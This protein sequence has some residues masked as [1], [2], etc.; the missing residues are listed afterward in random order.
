MI[1]SLSHLVRGAAVEAVL[2]GSE[3][4]TK[5]TLEAVGIDH[6]AEQP[7]RRPRGGTH[8]SPASPEGER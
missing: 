3:R 4:I 8:H 1:G 7:H 5:A 2:T 6:A